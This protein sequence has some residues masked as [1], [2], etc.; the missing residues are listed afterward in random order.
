[1]YASMSSS[2]QA[3]YMMMSF[4]AYCSQ[5]EHAEDNLGDLTM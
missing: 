4:D 5:A 3:S 2:E 1:M